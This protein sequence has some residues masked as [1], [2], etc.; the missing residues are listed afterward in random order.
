MNVLRQ[1]RVALE[2]AINSLRIECET[3]KASLS[4]EYDTNDSNKKKINHINK[5]LKQFEEVYK[6]YKIHFF[7]AYFCIL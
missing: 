1:E 2:E 5:L 6:F 7:N 3:L 4:R